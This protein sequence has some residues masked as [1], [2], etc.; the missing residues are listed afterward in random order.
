MLAETSYPTDMSS[1]HPFPLLRIG[2]LFLVFV[3]TAIVV[4]G[5]LPRRAWVLLSSGAIL[6]VVAAVVAGLSFLRPPGRPALV[7][8]VS[9]VIAI[10]VEIVGIVLVNSTLRSKGEPTLVLA[11]LLVVGVHFLLMAPA[12]GPLIVLLG[13]CSIGNAIAGLRLAPSRP[14]ALFWTVDGGLKVAVGSVMWL[15]A[16]RLDWG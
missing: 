13:T 11:T 3:G 15:L 14:W 5:I 6:G 16:P 10:V 7:Q 2:G 9:L 4:G 8:V 1:A 12:F